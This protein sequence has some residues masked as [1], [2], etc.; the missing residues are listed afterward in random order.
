MYI[1]RIMQLLQSGGSI[2]ALCKATK[3]LGRTSAL[4]KVEE[5]HIKLEKSISPH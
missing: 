5:P 1:I 2:Q 4:Q 3:K